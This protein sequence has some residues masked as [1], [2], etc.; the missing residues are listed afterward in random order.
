M[1]AADGRVV[2]AV[3][4]VNVASPLACARVRDMG[5]PDIYDN[6]DA[7]KREVTPPSLRKCDPER[8]GRMQLD[9]CI[10]VSP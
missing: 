9:H 2:L 6:R 3:F 5:D 10:G 8:S 4:A 1:L 7:T